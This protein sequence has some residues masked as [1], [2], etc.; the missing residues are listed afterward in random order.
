MLFD[1]SCDDDLTSGCTDAMKRPCCCVS[2]PDGFYR[3]VKQ[4]S[5]AHNKAENNPVAKGKKRRGSARG[6]A[7][8]VVGDSN[9]S[10]L[11]KCQCCRVG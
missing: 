8:S 10:L 6:M 7:P 11:F 5:G 3:Q 9:S 4:I 2:L 1:I